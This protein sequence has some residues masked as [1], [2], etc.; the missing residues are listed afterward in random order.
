MQAEG[1]PQQPQQQQPAEGA[2]GGDGVNLEAAVGQL[3]Q[4]LRG[5]LDQL[6]VALERPLDEDEVE[7][8]SDDD[9]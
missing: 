8:D 1:L 3:T 5:L 6:R 9:R 4:S 7:Q 2:V